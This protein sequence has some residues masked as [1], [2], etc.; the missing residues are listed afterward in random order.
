MRLSSS[1]I[2][3]CRSTGDLV[4]ICASPRFKMKTGQLTSVNGRR[5]RGMCGA[6]PSGVARLSAIDDGSRIT[7]GARSALCAAR[8]E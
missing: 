5:E 4:E 8:R 3:N 7:T 1:L 6:L 2:V